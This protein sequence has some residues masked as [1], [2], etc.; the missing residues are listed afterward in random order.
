MNWISVKD[1]LPDDYSDVLVYDYDGMQYD[2]GWY[3]FEGYKGWV[4]T[5]MEDSITHWM[6]L[7]EPP[8]EAIR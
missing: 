6:P 4:N 8:S 2:I 3:D 5:N 1:R 7:P